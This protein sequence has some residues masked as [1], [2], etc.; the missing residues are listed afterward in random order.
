MNHKKIAVISAITLTFMIGLM[1]LGSNRVRAAG[2]WYVDPAGNDS[3]SCTAPGAGNA[4][5]TIQAAV[6]KA[7]SGDTINVAAGTYSVTGANLNKAVTLSGAQAGVD[8]RDGRPGAQE[9]IIAGS[10]FGTFHLSAA[11]ITFDGFTFSNLQGRELDSTTNADNFTMRNCILQGNSIDPGYNTGAIQFGGGLSL[12]AN[13]LVFERNLVTADNGQLLYMG[14]AMDNGTIRN[15]IFHGDT[16]AFGPF[17]VRTGWL[18]EG[19]EFNGDVPG[20]GAYWGFA[21]NANLGDVVIRNNYVHKMQIGLGQISVVGGSITGNTFDDNSFAA[22]Q[23]WGGEFGSIVS[24]NVTV[25]NNRINYNGTACTGFADA[26]HGIRLRVGGDATTIHLHQNSFVDLG[27]GAC[28]QAWAIR[29]NDIGTADAD[30]NWWGIAGPSATIATHF[31]QGAVNFTPWISGYVD[32]PVHAGQLGF[33]PLLTTSTTILSDTPDPSTAG[34]AY[35]VSGT[36]EVT[37]L[38]GATS[39][40]SSLP[41][42]VV[43]SD[44]TDNCSATSLPDSGTLNKYA[45]SCSL[46]STTSGAKTLTATYTDTSVDPFYNTSNGTT[47]H[48]VQPPDTTAPT[49]IFVN[50][51]PSVGKSGTS[52]RLSSQATD[53]GGLKEVYYNLFTSGGSFVCNLSHVV[54]SG[55]PTSYTDGP[56][57]VGA[58]MPFAGLDTG[59]GGPCPAGGIPEGSYILT[60]NWIDAAG[61][62]VG[63]GFPANQNINSYPAAA[64]FSPIIYDNTPP[65]ITA[66]GTVTIMTGPT[67]TSCSVTVANLNAT[68]GTATANDNLTGIASIVRTGV[69][70]GNVFPVGNTTVTY[71]ATD[72]AGN[73]ASA[74]QT[75]KVVDNTAPA[76]TLIGANPL[77]VPYGSVFTDPGAT[78]LDNCAG[79]L[80]GSIV[81]TG[82]VNTFAVGTYTRT[83][84]VSDGTNTTIKTRTVKVVANPPTNKDQC[85]D[86]GWKNLTRADGSTFKNQGDCIQY[87]NTG[88]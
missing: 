1:F 49:V 75:V 68:L 20:H 25:A 88:K 69:P 32:D 40:L 34:S 44:A 53:S 6:V 15:N 85:K 29:Q 10:G 47:S 7:A 2:T 18:I 35:T 54:V 65:T 67:A 84:T 22:F 82:T 70:A 62:Q 77:I 78:A 87:A 31:G 27:V 76:I 74:N 21:F 59:V 41:G 33:W 42:Q 14:H 16:V 43:V 23:L 13:G 51:V 28:S 8:A 45:F 36:V 9:S 3:N 86:D 56:T 81:A 71:T 46:T 57:P 55:S 73:T 24:S 83:Y 17:G 58:T 61:N 80:T 5:L 64:R 11:N 12:H 19:N 48:N 63:G 60:A 50:S 38:G 37:G 39:N 72:G 66:P 52:I 30:L 4:C 79:N 26:S